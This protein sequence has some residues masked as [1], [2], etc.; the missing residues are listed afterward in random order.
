MLRITNIKL[1]LDED[2]N[3]L[4]SKVAKKLKIPEKSILS[5]KIHRKSVDARNKN[6]VHF[7]YTV[8]VKLENESKI[9]KI[10]SNKG[11]S[12]VKDINI[13]YEKI[14]N[15]K[16]TRPIV[17]GTGP[18]GLFAGLALARM[19]FRPILFERGKSVDERVIDVNP[20][21]RKEN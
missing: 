5:L 17:V 7:V 9:L 20:F 15:E 6:D 12:E 1:S 14:V 13:K 16:I 19:G 11:V 18:A 10:Y 2:E 21:G 3:L 8:D 4:K